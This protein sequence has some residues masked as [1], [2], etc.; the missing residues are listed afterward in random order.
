[1]D[2][3]NGRKYQHKKFSVMGT[4]GV[5]ARVSEHGEVVNAASVSENEDVVNAA[6]V[7]EHGR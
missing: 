7:S 6:R 3:Y 2:G 1:M 5:A 4:L